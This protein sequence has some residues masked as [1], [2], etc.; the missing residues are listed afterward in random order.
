ML[1]TLSDW[2]VQVVLLCSCCAMVLC[3]VE[4]VL[5]AHLGH[6]GATPVATPNVL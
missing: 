2:Q 6:R 4:T 3:D 5:L 1:P